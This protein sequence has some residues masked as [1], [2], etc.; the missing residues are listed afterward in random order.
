MNKKLYIILGI[1]VILLL[2]LVVYFFAVNKKLDNIYDNMKVNKNTEVIDSREDVNSEVLGDTKVNSNEKIDIKVIKE[3]IDNKLENKE[4]EESTNNDELVINNLN[5]TLNN[6]DNM[7]KLSIKEKAKEIF[8]SIVDFLLYDGE[9]NGVTFNELS[10]KGKE[11]V[12]KVIRKID[13]KLDGLSPGYK[14]TITSNGKEVFNKLSEVIKSG[15]SEI[16]D[17]FEKKD[18]IK[19]KEEVKEYSE[20]LKNNGSK[21]LTSTKDKLN[22]VIKNFKK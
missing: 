1:L 8:I 6:I 21:I 4:K 16:K 14:D 17:Y 22:E 18:L 3:N 2:F 9:I 7:D 19:L 13:E 11:N 15:K 10:E 12:L 5:E 20:V